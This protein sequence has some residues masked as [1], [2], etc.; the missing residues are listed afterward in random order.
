VKNFFHNKVDFSCC[1]EKNF[2]FLREVIKM[3][4]KAGSYNFILKI[5]DAPLQGAPWI[6]SYS[7]L[8]DRMLK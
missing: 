3:I 5:Q 4:E 6:A 2:L 8:W 1:Q 7:I